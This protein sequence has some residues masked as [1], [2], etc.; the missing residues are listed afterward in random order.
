MFFFARKM[1]A[2]CLS[3]MCVK[4][5]SFGAQDKTPATYA[6][7]RSPSAPGRSRLKEKQVG[8]ASIDARNQS[9][10]HMF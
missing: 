2:F 9:G 8:P 10:R 7:S 5:F 4:T 6:R 1:F 3:D